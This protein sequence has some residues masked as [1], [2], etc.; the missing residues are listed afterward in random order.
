MSWIDIKEEGSIE[1][2]TVS[3]EPSRQVSITIIA[4][5]NI[6]DNSSIV[7]RNPNG[8]NIQEFK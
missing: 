1:T 2:V 5:Q 6:N 8:F 3:I 4:Y 7:F